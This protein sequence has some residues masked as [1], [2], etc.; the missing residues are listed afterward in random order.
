MI[1]EYKTY[2]NKDSWSNEDKIT[3]W[4]KGNF[5][6]GYE[7]SKWRRDKYGNEI[8]WEDYGNRK[9]RYGW[10]IGQINLISNGVVNNIVNLNPL[11]WKNT[12]H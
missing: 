7:P 4:E 2:T 9:S 11:H 6:T 10:E 8:K 1:Q 3:I 12:S 5:I